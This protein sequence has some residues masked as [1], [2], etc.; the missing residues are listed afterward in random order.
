MLL[1]FRYFFNVIS[2]P[3]VQDNLLIRETFS[4]STEGIKFLESSLFLAT[5]GPEDD[6]SAK[7]EDKY[8]FCLRESNLRILTTVLRS[9]ALRVLDS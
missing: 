4:S 9:F 8:G 1:T 3:T 7:A 5:V 2:T 6:V